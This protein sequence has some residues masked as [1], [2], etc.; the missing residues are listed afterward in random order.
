MGKSQMVF[1]PRMDTR[2]QMREREQKASQHPGLFSWEEE[3][4][5][6]YPTLSSS[7]QKP[8]GP[9]AAAG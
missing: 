2:V 9:R 1:T 3:R 4:W 5:D 8:P 6:P 7:R